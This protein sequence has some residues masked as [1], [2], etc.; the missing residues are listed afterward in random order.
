MRSRYNNRNNG[1][2]DDMC[3]NMLVIKK[4][5]VANRFKKCRLPNIVDNRSLKLT[6]WKIAQKNLVESTSSILLKL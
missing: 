3:I 6:W 2:I 1:K 4:Y 5:N